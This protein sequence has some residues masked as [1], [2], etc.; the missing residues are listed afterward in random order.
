MTNLRRVTAC[1]R[2]G[3][4]DRT[5]HVH[6]GYYEPKKDPWDYDARTL[7]SLCE[8]C[9]RNAADGLLELQIN[10]AE[11]PIHVQEYLQD[12]VQHFRWMSHAEQQ[13]MAIAAVAQASAQIEE[14]A[15]LWRKEGVPSLVTG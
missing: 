5:L 8:A 10:L 1:E 11:T 9:H 14:S 6:H 12:I 13:A 15:E 2:C 3:R 4:N 7:H